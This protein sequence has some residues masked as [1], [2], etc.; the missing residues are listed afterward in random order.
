MPYR[1]EP[2]APKALHSNRSTISSS[3]L[4]ESKFSIIIWFFR[5]ILSIILI[6]FIMPFAL[7]LTPW[8]IWLQPF[9]RKC[10]DM[11]DGYYRLVTWP[12]TLSKKIRLYQDDD[13]FASQLKY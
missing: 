7:L 5:I 4:K 11:M 12:L 9:Q 1:V 8:W 6:L 10:P 2:S 3:S 13:H